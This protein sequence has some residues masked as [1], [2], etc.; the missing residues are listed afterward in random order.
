MNGK[1]SVVI[2]GTSYAVEELTEK[3]KALLES[4]DFAEKELAEAQARIAI[5]NT[6]KST[7]LSLIKKELPTK[8]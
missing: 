7:Y 1:R 3:G 5:L 8:K 6:A 2:D 4:V